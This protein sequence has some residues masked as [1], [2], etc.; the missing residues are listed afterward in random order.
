[1]NQILMYL[2]AAGAIL[3][4]IDRIFGNRHGY[5]AKFEEGFLFLGPTALSMGGMIC[6]A[7]V[8]AN[9]LGKGIIPIYQWFDIDPAMFGG[10]LAIDMGGFP[11]AKELAETPL[12][13]SYAGIVVAAT[14]GCTIVFTIPVGLGII[15]P[16]DHSS[17][18]RGILIGLAALPAALTAGGLV[19]GM[20]LFQVLKQNLLILLFSVLL[21]IGLWKLPEQMTKG[22]RIFAKG[23]HIIIT[24]GL[25]LAAITS[26]TG[27]TVVPGMAPLEEALAVVASI[28]IVML[29]SLPL[30]EFLKRLMKRPF[31]WFGRKLR[32]N[33]TSVA[34]LLVGMV[35]VV[36]AITMLKD[37][38]KRGKVINVAAM[39]S[40]A[41]LLAAHLGFTVSAAPDMVAALLAAKLSGGITAV[42]VAAIVTANSKNGQIEKQR[43]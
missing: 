26:M 21:V 20:T 40:A 9:I 7:P 28:G 35:S 8:L 37:M 11:L 30:A 32:I 29:G 39:V 16:E 17:F 43:N 14:F 10:I 22:F 3:G 31:A 38:D 42:A 13:G 5:G 33:D 27:Y 18:A 24:I 23:I 19:C 12:I 36:P 2:M 41:S 1:M 15:A 6:L 34:G 25:L 4:G